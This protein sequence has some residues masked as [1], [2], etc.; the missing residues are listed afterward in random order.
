MSRFSA[1]ARTHVAGLSL[2]AAA[3]VVASGGCAPRSTRFDIVDHRAA[4]GPTSYFE[5]FD[6]CCYST[7]ASGC[8]DL[9]ARRIGFGEGDTDE[10]IIQV[11]HLHGIW[12]SMP[13]RT[14]AEDTMINATVSYMIV[15]GAGG[16]SFDGAGFV[17]FRENRDR[18][19]AAGHLELAKLAPVRRLGDGQQIFERAELKGEFKATRNRRQVIRILSEMRRLLGPLPRYQPPAT[20]ADLL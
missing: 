16:A 13:G 2:W 14:Y 10:R 9:V 20:D 5:N 11:V 19:V 3:C 12:H 18:T 15:G 7:D 8:F 17:S 6:E 1:K 4:G